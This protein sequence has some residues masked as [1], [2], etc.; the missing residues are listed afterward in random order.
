[1]EKYELKKKYYRLKDGS[2]ITLEDN[3]QID[4]LNKLVTVFLFISVVYN[5]SNDDN[6]SL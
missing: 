3:K 4:F 1:M 5:P 2:F 6:T